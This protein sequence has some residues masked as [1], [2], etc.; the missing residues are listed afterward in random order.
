ME[1]ENL[2]NQGTATAISSIEL[3]CSKLKKQYNENYGTIFSKKI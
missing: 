1:K 2:N 3:I